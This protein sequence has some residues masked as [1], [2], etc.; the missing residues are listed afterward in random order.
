MTKFRK[1]NTQTETAGTVSTEEEF[2]SDNLP[3]VCD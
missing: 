2:S 1:D 3:Q